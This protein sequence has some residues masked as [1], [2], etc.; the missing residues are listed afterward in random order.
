MIVSFFQGAQNTIALEGIGNKMR[1]MVE[2]LIA[3]ALEAGFDAAGALDCS[4][5]ILRPDVRDACET[6]KCGR[7]GK[8]WSCPP[9]CGSLDECAA[10][11]RRYAKGLIVQTVGKLEDQFDGE[12]IMAAA[13][14]HEQSFRRI[15]KE[16]RRD[17]PG[18]LPLGTEGCSNCDLCSYP[19]APC[20]DPLGASSPMEA[21]GMMVRDVCKANGMEY[22]HGKDTIT[23]TGC[24]LLE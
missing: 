2:R 16:L 22:Y 9:G 8:N 13:Q 10:R 11:I 20:R 15:S 7:Y 21:F 24:F 6:N 3:K 18:M 17:Y 5:I 1:Q 19:D 12:G 4:T 14:R 23:F